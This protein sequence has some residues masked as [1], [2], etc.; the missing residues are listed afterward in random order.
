MTHFVTEKMVNFLL[1]FFK[2]LEF[3]DFLGH[4]QGYDHLMSWQLLQ[5]LWI[6]LCWYPSYQTLSKMFHRDWKSGFCYFQN[7]Q[8]KYNLDRQQPRLLET[9]SI[10]LRNP[11]NRKKLKLFHLR[12]RFGFYDCLNRIQLLCL[13]SI[14]LCNGGVPN[15][16]LCF[17]WSRICQRTCHL[18]GK[19]EIISWLLFSSSL[20]IC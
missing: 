6:L 20:V 12:Q 2:T 3:Y 17:R 15:G 11:L 18:I 8:H 13:C 7:P 5:D 10:H 16:R 1:N 19:P 4:T 9:W 14:L